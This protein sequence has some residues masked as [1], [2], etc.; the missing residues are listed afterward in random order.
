[1]LDLGTPLQNSLSELWSILNFIL[2]DTF[3]ELDAF[4][5]WF[6]FSQVGQ[7]QGQEALVAAEQ[8]DRVVSKL[9]SILRPFF[10]RRLKSDVEIELPAKQE[11][12]LYAHMTPYQQKINQ[13]ILDKSLFAKLEK[14]VKTKAV[15]GLAKGKLRQICM[16]MRKNCNHP[17]LITGGYDGA[18]EYPPVSVLLDQ[19]GKLQLLD[20]LLEKLKA[21]GHKVLI[22]S[23]MRRMLDI[24]EYYLTENGEEPCRLDGSVKVAER[25]LHMERFNTDSSLWLFLLTTTAGG[26]G[27]NLTAADTVIIYD[28]DWN[29]QQDLQ[30]MD[31]CHRIGQSKPVLVFRLVTGHSVEGRMLKRASSKIVLERL[32]MKKGAFQGDHFV[33]DIPSTSLTVEEILPLLRSDVSLED[34]IQSK[35]VSDKTL[36]RLLNRTHLLKKETS[37]KLPYPRSNPGYEVV[38]KNDNATILPSIN[39]D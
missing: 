23:Q 24:L 1:M 3:S 29:P 28:S 10:L 12:V 35:V 31:R 30:A 19:C 26:L 17:D 7:V 39:K 25:Q 18:I 8:R 15:R 32:V 6:D 33:S 34:D 20:K 27:I 5:K 37:A 36:D 9:H 2:P 4:E 11:I 14:E 38:V 21:N 22:F 16:Q 13:G